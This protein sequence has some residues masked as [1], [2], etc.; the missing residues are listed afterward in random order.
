MEFYSN[1]TPS[2]PIVP[3]TYQAY[4][5]KDPEPNLLGSWVEL[6]T[7][8]DLHIP[9]MEARNFP[10]PR[11]IDVPAHLCVSVQNTPTLPYNLHVRQVTLVQK[12]LN[13]GQNVEIFNFD[14]QREHHIPKDTVVARAFFRELQRVH[15][16][17]DHTDEGTTYQVMA[18]G[19]R[20]NLDSNYQ[21]YSGNLAP[22]KVK[23]TER[24]STPFPSPRPTRRYPPAKERPMEEVCREESIRLQFTSKYNIDSQDLDESLLINAPAVNKMLQGFLGKARHYHRVIKRSTPGMTIYVPITPFETERLQLLLSLYLNH[25]YEILRADLQSYHTMDDGIRCVL[26]IS[27]IH[28]YDNVQDSTSSSSSFHENGTTDS[29]RNGGNTGWRFWRGWG[30]P[31]VAARPKSSERGNESPEDGED[32]EESPSYEPLSDV[33]DLS[34]LSSCEPLSRSNSYEEILKAIDTS[35]DQWNQYEERIQRQLDILRESN[36]MSPSEQTP[37]GDEA[38]LDMSVDKES[39]PQAMEEEPVPHTTVHASHSI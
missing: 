1:P 33:A 12:D 16:I 3:I 22:Y 39:L 19:M 38:P 4:D 7:S 26:M 14:A 30:I 25:Q 9:P 10:F 17:A 6:A 31:A 13:Q 18:K 27:L 34:S 36:A 2:L 29:S 37:E 20:G 35:L 28:R 15:F 11:G 8:I 5:E 32:E 23:R 24:P 21:A